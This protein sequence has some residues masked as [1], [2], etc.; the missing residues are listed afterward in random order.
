MWLGYMALI[1][2]GERHLRYRKILN[3]LFST[4][5]IRVIL[6]LLSP[7]A[8]EVKSSFVI[9]RFFLTISVQLRDV[10]SR[11]VTNGPQVVDLLP[12]FSKSSLECTGR[13][14][15]DY[16]FGSLE[17]EENAAFSGLVSSLG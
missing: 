2:T 15:F 11:I 14:G 16:S 5:Q 10:I 1:L 4:R 13:G 6:P 12:W 9:K 7:V 17:D 8:D 3:P